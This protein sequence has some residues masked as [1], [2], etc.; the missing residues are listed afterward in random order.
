MLI[1][2]IKSREI[3]RIDNRENVSFACP[4]DSLPDARQRPVL[5]LVCTALMC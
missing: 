2:M 5:Q 4:Q 1:M 3:N